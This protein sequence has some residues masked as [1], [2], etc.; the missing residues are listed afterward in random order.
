MTCR[1]LFTGVFI[2]VAIYLLLVL[3]QQMI[4]AV[5]ASSNSYPATVQKPNTRNRIL[6]RFVRPQ[7]QYNKIRPEIFNDFFGIQHF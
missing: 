3:Q 2:T 6:T 1:V 4:G 7:N 5:E